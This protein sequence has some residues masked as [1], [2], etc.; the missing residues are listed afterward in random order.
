MFSRDPTFSWNH[1][2]IGW[3]YLEKG[4]FDKA[5]KEFKYEKLPYEQ[6]R[7]GLAVAYANTGKTG[8]ARKI[9]SQF[10]QLARERYVSPAAFILIHLALGE[11]DKAF[12][13]LEKAYEARDFFLCEIKVNPR[14]DPLRSDQRFTSLIQRVGLVH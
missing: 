10:Y 6:G 2:W 1:N 11:K 3:V 8:E 4:E 13:W 14:L 5:I 7:W 12:E 9:L